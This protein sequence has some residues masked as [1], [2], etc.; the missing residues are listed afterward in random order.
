M[1]LRAITFVATLVGLASAEVFPRGVDASF[2]TL[3]QADINMFTPY[4]YYAAAVKCNPQ[5]VSSWQCGRTYLTYGPFL[6][7]SKEKGTVQ[8]LNWF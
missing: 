7:S 3:T 5:V 8:H 1:F 6:Y 2:V 4:T